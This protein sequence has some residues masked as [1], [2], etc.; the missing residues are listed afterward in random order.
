MIQKSRLHPRLPR[1]RSINSA[2]PGPAGRDYET[3]TQ[4]MNVLKIKKNL[5]NHL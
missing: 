3:I 2:G 1:P 4:I 5:C